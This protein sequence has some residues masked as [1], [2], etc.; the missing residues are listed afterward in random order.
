MQIEKEDYLHVA[1]VLEETRTALSMRNALA[2]KQLSDHVMHGACSYQDSGTITMT[3]LIYTLSKLIERGDNARIKNWQKLEQKLIL[4]LGLAA[5]ALR[6]Q[7]NSKFEEYMEQARNTLT[8]YSIN[9]KPYIQ[10]VM[11][12]SAINKGLKMYEHGLSQEKTAR[13]LGITQWELSEYIGQKTFTDKKQ[14][15]SMD[16]KKRAKMAMEFFS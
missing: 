3:V 12:K 13:L 1:E 16:I 14:I 15:Q 9:L 6:A 10:D 4:Y 5:Q 7:K 8:S 11:K 2:L